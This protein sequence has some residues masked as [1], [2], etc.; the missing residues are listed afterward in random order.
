MSHPRFEQT[1]G[2]L[3]NDEFFSGLV[4][5]CQASI[6]IYELF[7]KS[8]ICDGVSLKS[9]KGWVALA[10]TCSQKYVSLLEQTLLQYSR[11]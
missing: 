1:D 2:E 8:L 9:P 7:T 10:K 4:V 3:Y 5:W 6:K 11:G